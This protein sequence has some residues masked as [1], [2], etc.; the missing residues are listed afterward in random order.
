M[1]SLSISDTPKPSAWNE[2]LS[3][4]STALYKFTSFEINLDES[5]KIFTRET[6]DVLSWLG[7]CGGLKGGVFW[8]GS[9]LMSAFSTFSL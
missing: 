4:N 1:I 3:T 6:Y 2:N 8:I 9:V 7:D 5:I